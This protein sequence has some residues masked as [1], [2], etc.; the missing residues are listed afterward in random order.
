[1]GSSEAVLSSW[2]YSVVVDKDNRE[3][4]N[5]LISTWRKCQRFKKY[6]FP[7]IEINRHGMLTRSW[8]IEN[9][10]VQK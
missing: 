1:M 5:N 9:I 2:A 7:Y 4:Q 6:F 10:L 3:I 8:N